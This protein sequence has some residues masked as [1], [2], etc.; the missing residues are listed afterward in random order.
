MTH[1]ILF[2]LSP[3]V[4]GLGIGKSISGTRCF[5]T[6]STR[7][8]QKGTKFL[9]GLA[10]KKEVFLCGFVRCLKPKDCNVLCSAGTALQLLQSVFAFVQFGVRGYT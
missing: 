3:P 2:H 6:N 1:L 7:L 5:V 9:S 4:P 8:V 10:A